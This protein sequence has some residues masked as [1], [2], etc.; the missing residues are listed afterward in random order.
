MLPSHGVCLCVCPPGC[1]SINVFSVFGRSRRM[2]DLSW[3]FQR[4]TNSSLVVLVI[5]PVFHANARKSAQPT[6]RPQI[7]AK[8]TQ[9][10]QTTTNFRKFWRKTN[11]P[12]KPTI[13]TKIFVGS[14]PGR[15]REAVSSVCPRRGQGC[16]VSGGY[17]TPFNLN[18]P[19]GCVGP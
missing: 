19:I 11:K 4:P 18:N 7:G 1:W 6:I 16:E 10:Q 8:H 13:K 5:D 17:F 12:T 3:I 14:F 2:E 15:R 9:N